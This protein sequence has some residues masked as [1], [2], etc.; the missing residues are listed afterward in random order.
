MGQMIVEVTFLIGP[1][2]SGMKMWNTNLKF[3]LSKYFFSAK[4]CKQFIYGGCSNRTENS[5]SSKAACQK[6]C[7]MPINVKKKSTINMVT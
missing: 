1:M 6:K 3:N 2:T 4:K 7:S 5:F